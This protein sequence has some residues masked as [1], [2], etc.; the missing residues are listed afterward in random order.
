[1]LVIATDGVAGASHRRIA[2]LAG[3]SLG[4]MTY[5]FDG[6]DDILAAAFSDFAARSATAFAGYFADARTPAQARAAT[7]E[8]LAASSEPMRDP[9]PIVPENPAQVFRELGPGGEIVL[10]SELY[11]LAV[12]KPRF[13]A[14]LSS[15]IRQCRAVLADHFDADTTLMIDAFYEGLLLHRYMNIGAHPR[16]LIEAAVD[17]LAP[18]SACTDGAYRCPTSPNR[19]EVNIQ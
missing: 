17:R 2:G 3:V 15:W 9:A 19:D 7:V 5:H 13:Q 1:M 6:I 16:A 4:T 14:V 8:M 12:R 10:G 11:A 18:D